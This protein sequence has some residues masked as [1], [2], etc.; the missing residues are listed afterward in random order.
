M[1]VTMRE[2]VVEALA[3]AHRAS[4]PWVEHAVVTFEHAPTE[5]ERAEG[6]RRFLER[7]RADGL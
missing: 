7:R 4:E 2:D 6:L 3:A 1:G 5:A